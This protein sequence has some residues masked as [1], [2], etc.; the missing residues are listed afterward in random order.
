[1]SCWALKNKSNCFVA[2][3]LNK[4]KLVPLGEN[5][6]VLGSQEDNALATLQN[7][8]TLICKNLNM[9]CLETSTH[10]QQAQRNQILPLLT[11]DIRSRITMKQQPTARKM[12]LLDENQPKLAPSVLWGGVKHPRPKD[13]N[14]NTKINVSIPPH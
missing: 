5:L 6:G 1:M 11:V 10:K 12:E 13:V 2:L 4:G 3:S 14:E 8:R 9:A 7:K